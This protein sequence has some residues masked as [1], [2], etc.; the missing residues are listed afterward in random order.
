VLRDRDET[1]PEALAN[2][3]DADQARQRLEADLAGREA[4]FSREPDLWDT[5]ISLARTAGLLAKM[6]DRADAAALTR[7]QALLGRAADLLSGP[8]V[9]GR[10]LPADRELQARIQTMR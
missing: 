4:D 9:E 1:L 6:L 2:T 3:G 7:R 10:L 5:R 8:D